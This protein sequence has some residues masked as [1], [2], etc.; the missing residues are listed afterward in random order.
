[1]SQETTQNDRLD[2]PVKMAPW[3]SKSEMVTNWRNFQ[4]L[5]A[6]QKMTKKIQN[7]KNPIFPDQKF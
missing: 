7:A 1:M 2:L 3:R 5:T 4:K 6:T